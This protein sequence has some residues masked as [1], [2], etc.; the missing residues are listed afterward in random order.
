MIVQYVLCVW[1]DV[2]FQ[3]HVT[4]GCGKFIKFGICN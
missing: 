2:L 1:N 4:K 3:V